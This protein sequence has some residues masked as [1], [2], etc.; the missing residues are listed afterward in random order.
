MSRLE[1]V[2]L[3]MVVVDVTPE[4]KRQLWASQLAILT[5]VNA[6]T[7]PSSLTVAKLKAMR[8]RY[9]P[10]TSWGEVFGVVHD[11]WNTWQVVFQRGGDDCESL[12]ALVAAAAA[13]EGA[14]SVGV[15][16]TDH[17][18]WSDVNGEPVDLC[19]LGGMPAPPSDWYYGPT[20]VRVPIVGG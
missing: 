1:T 7:L 5:G 16:I 15:N 14:S 6:I 9:I 13:L 3:A 18:A 11:V 2:K 4:Q 8:L 17:H 19:V 20:R 12:T 10:D